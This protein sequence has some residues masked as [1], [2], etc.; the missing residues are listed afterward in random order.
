M[1]LQREA[2]EIRIYLQENISLGYVI[3]SRN[4]FKLNFKGSRIDIV[5]VFQKKKK[6]VGMQQKNNF[7]KCNIFLIH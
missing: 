3:P 6:C 1:Q 4:L 2:S 5:E 7:N